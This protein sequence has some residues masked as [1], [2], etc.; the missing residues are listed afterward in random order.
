VR[1][2]QALRFYPDPAYDYEYPDLYMRAFGEAYRPPPY[3][4]KA[5]E[6]ARNHK[7]YEA[8]RLV[9]TNDLYSFDPDMKVEIEQFEDVI[10]RC[11]RQPAEGLGFDDSPVFAHV[12]QHHLAEQFSLKLAA[13]YVVDITDPVSDC[14]PC[15]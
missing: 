13:L 4:A 3:V 1:Y 5:A 2:H 14:P 6:Y 15:D 11:F 12:A 10:G 8:A 9:T 7:W